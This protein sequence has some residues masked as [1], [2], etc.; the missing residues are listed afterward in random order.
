MTAVLTVVVVLVAVVAVVVV[1]NVVMRRRGYGIPGTTAVRC[2]AGHL[3]RT[4]WI[5]GGSLRPSASA[6]RRGGSGARWGHTGRSS[7]RSGRT[8]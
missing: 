7:T 5:E 4:T 8:T 1:Q 6:R 3:F 2:S